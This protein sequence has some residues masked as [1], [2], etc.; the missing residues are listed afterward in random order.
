MHTLADEPHSASLWHIA[1]RPFQIL[2]HPLHSHK[3]C[4][5]GSEYSIPSIYELLVRRAKRCAPSRS[6]WD[7]LVR[8]R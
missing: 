5:E 7:A 3:R 4:A 2:H 8:R 1:L 6:R